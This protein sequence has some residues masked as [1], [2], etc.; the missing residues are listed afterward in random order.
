MVERLLRCGARPRIF[1]RDAKKARLRFADR[2]DVFV[3]DLADPVALK[4]ALEGVDELFLVNTGP[5]IPTRD[6]GPRML[7][8]PP[9]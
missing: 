6:E 8:K 2:V 9:A 3:G 1:V 5:Q 4:T 7:A